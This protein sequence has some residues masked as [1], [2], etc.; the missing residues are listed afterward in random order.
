MQFK[1]TTAWLAIIVGF[2]ATGLIMAPG[3]SANRMSK[4]QKNGEKLYMANCEACHMLGTNVIKPDKQLHSS[5]QLATRAM[6]KAYISKKHGVMP[7]FKQLADDEK[8]LK[9]LY[10]FVRTLKGQD[11]EVTKGD[12]AEEHHTRDL[13]MKDRQ[14]P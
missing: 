4:S 5:E 9:E 8:S 12:D 2:A 3:F 10:S 13:P 6:F 1:T 14:D 11:W 7:P